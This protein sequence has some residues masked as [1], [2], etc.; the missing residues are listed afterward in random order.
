MSG[1]VGGTSNSTNNEAKLWEAILGKDPKTIPRP[2]DNKDQ[3]G[4]EAEQD[5]V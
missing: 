1:S 2:G 5:I 4:E 3:P